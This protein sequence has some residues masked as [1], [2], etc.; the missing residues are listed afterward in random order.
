MN[1]I[2]SL[3]IVLLTIGVG[4]AYAQ[5]LDDVNTTV[6]DYDGNYA[7]IQLSWNA[8]STV[9]LYEVGCVSCIP[10]TSQNVF[11]TSVT[12]HEITPIPN[13]ATVLLYIIAFDESKEII[14]VKQVILDI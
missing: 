7:T 1:P 8:D 4:L 14:A 11:G 6:L 12:M 2:Y 9:S 5:P 10:N 13:S 3:F